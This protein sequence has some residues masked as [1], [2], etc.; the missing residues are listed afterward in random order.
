MRSIHL[1]CVYFL[2]FLLLTLH[3]VS[4]FA[5]ALCF[6]SSSSKLPVSLVSLSLSSFLS[7]ISPAWIH[8]I[9]IYQDEYARWELLVPKVVIAGDINRLHSLAGIGILRLIPI[10]SWFADLN[11]QFMVL[12]AF[13]QN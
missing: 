4:V 13:R 12:H 11:F 6:S 2:F 1:F 3:L 8:T 5:A 10:V 9:R 7:A